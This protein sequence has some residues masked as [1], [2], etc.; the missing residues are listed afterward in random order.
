M[1]LPKDRIEIANFKSKV[2]QQHQ[3]L[4]SMDLVDTVKSLLKQKGRDIWSVSPEACVYDAVEMMADK[5]VGALLVISEGRLV[6][7]ISERDYARKIILQGKSSKQAQVKEIMTS[8]V[9]FVAPE[10]TV[11]ECMRIMTNSR[12]RHLP[13]VDNEKVLGVISIGDLV[14][15]II[16]AQE[17]TIHQLKHYI[18]GSY[19]G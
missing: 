19:P 6:G 8:P 14:K 9:I 4:K 15:S 17:E 3:V 5:Q 10:H 2:V 16:S 18:A 1:V 12:I 7:V 13:V 11:E